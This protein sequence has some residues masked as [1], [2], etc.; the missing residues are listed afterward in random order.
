MNNEDTPVDKPK[1]IRATK[2]KKAKMRQITITPEIVINS[3]EI[4]KTIR[5][6]VYNWAGP[7]MERICRLLPGCTSDHLPQKDWKYYRVSYGGGNSRHA[8]V[9]KNLTDS[10]VKEIEEKSTPKKFNYIVTIRQA[11][12]S[13]IV[14]E[15]QLTQKGITNLNN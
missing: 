12:S 15:F 7:V 2:G 5:E 13:Q 4:A 11:E 3:N 14:D 6:S 9:V 8:S 10:E 1:S